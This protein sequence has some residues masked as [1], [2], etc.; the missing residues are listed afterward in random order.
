MSEIEDPTAQEFVDPSNQS[1]VPGS[2]HFP[3]PGIVLFSQ[4]GVSVGLALVAALLCQFIAQLNGWDLSNVMQSF[5]KDATYAERWQM[6]IYQMCSHMS[7][8]LA[9]GMVVLSLFYARASGNKPNWKSYL[10]TQWPGF[11]TIVLSVLMA[12]V[13]WPLV[14]YSYALNKAIPL[15]ESMRVAEQLY[16]DAIKG[17]MQMENVGEFAGNFFLVAVLAALGEE[18]VFRGVV[19]QQLVR[20]MKQP[21][22]AICTTALIFSLIHFEFAGLLPRFMLGVILG[23]LY[24]KTGNIWASISAH[25]FVNGIQVV[26]MYLFALGKVTV[27]PENDVEVPAFVAL[28]SLF[29]VWA[30]ARFFVKK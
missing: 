19:Q 16:Q 8:F 21:W 27:N 30:T 25:L 17:L 29:L 28:I 3:T 24:W 7:S 26:M 1:Q 14:F 5:S 18:L 15:P 23:W 22:L 4:L 13:A 12:I 6:R 9:A 2:Y 11:R 20:L 10:G